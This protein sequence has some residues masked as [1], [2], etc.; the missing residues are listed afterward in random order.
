[1]HGTLSRVVCRRC[2][3]VMQAEDFV[4]HIRPAFASGDKKEMRQAIKCECGKIFDTDVVLYDD[5]VNGVEQAWDLAQKC[6]L[7]LVVGTS[8]TT[9]PAAMLPEVAARHGA[10]II[11]V[12]DDCIKQ[13]TEDDE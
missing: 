1:M 13:L 7:M 2:G 12:N 9:Y 8:L 11:L 10:E 5:S 6:D 3:K 4:E